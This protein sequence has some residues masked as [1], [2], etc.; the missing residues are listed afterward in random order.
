[1]S[2]L[3]VGAGKASINPTPDMYPV[4]SPPV[5]DWGLKP[6]Q[7]EAIYDDMNCR[8]IAIDNGKEKMMFISYELSGPPHIRDFTQ[9]IES[10]TGFPKENI[11]IYGTHNHTGLREDPASVRYQPSQEEI[12]HMT[13][14]KDIC[15]K[16]GLEAAK[17]A[18]DSM[19]PAKYGY[20][21]IDSYINTNRDLQTRFGYWVEARNLA[22]YSDKTLA[23]IKFVDQDGKLIASLLNHPTHAT[24]CYL[25]QDADHIRKTSGNF[26]GIASR[27]VE[28]HYGNGAVCLWSS[29]AAGNQNPLLS[30]GLQY[31]YPDGYTSAV[32][33]PDGVGHMQMELM[34]RTHGSDAIKGL[35]SIADL[36][37]NMPIKHLRKSVLL[38]AQKKV[39]LKGPTTAFRMGGRGTDRSDV[40]FGQVPPVPSGPEMVDDTENPVELKLQLAVLGDV[41][42]ICANAELYCQIGRDMKLASPYKKTFVMTHTEADKAGYILDESSAHH[43]VFQ[44]FSKVKPGSADKLIINAE[45]ELFEEALAK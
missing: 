14:Y 39:N 17:A 4:P 40:P 25:M 9:Q 22:G 24:C 13:K 12:D 21:E 42:I 29:G 18:V 15:R 28:E 20:G 7:I 34:G 11:V 1:M 5:S 16:A 45:L 35:E 30:H 38:P 26:N 27:F 19:R 32:D 37:E 31:E 6:I 3:K 33:Y 2:L 8:A 43:K 23:I 10:L 36:S 41:A 44:A